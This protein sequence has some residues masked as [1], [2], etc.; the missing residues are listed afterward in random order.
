MPFK[1]QV[2]HESNQEPVK[3]GL[4]W[5]KIKS[6]MVKPGQPLVNLY[7]PWVKPG[8][9]WVKSS[10]PLVKPGRKRVKTHVPNVCWRQTCRNGM[11]IHRSNALS[12]SNQCHVQS[13]TAPAAVSEL[14]S[15]RNN[16]RIYKTEKSQLEKGYNDNN[17]KAAKSMKVCKKV[18][19]H[20][21]DLNKQCYSNKHQ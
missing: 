18:T 4:T 13:P 17:A 8:P 6:A 15:L 10:L 11:F 20:G 9:P 7:L 5:V 14:Q 2:Y 1:T 12:D 16:K 3:P 21:A 19:R